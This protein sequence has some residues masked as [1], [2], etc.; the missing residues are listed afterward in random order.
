MDTET[1]AVEVRHD[2]EV[3]AR[4][5]SGDSI[6][7]HN[8][9]WMHILRHQG[10]SVDYAMRFGGWAIVSISPDEGGHGEAT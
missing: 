2:G 8:D 10:Q 4:Y 7:D 6:K 3:K 9:A 1:G 5:D